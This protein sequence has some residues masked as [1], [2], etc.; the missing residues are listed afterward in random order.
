MIIPQ[1]NIS[2]FISKNDGQNSLYKLHVPTNV[3][4]EMVKKEITYLLRK[5]QE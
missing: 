1:E 2:T 4:F 5:E 3:F